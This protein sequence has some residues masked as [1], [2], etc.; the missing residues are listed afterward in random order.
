MNGTDGVA[1]T[2]LRLAVGRIAPPINRKRNGSRIT[3][4]TAPRHK[5][6]GGAWVCLGVWG[7]GAGRV[8]VKKKKGTQGRPARG[9]DTARRIFEITK[10]IKE[11][12]YGPEEA[13]AE[14]TA[15]P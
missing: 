2:Q 5:T 6:P 14:N 7:W 8:P 4:K 13:C 3:N 9:G 10:E 11:L 1:T 15:Q 12:E